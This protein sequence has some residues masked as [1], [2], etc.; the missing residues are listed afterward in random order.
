[1]NILIENFLEHSSKLFLNFD[2]KMCGRESSLITGTDVL[3]ELHCAG[4]AVTNFYQF[5][6]FPQML[7][8][9]IF[10]SIPEA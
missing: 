7:R 3:W 6:G 2:A 1:M 10:Q 8:T 5:E 9:I 4:Y